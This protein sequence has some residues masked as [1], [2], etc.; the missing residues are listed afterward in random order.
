M[1]MR[2]ITLAVSA[3][4]IAAVATIGGTTVTAGAAD[5]NT[6]T[7]GTLATYKFTG[8]SNLA[9]NP[10]DQGG[11]AAQAFVMYWNGSGWRQAV[12][13]QWSPLG[14]HLYVADNYSDNRFAWG[15]IRDVETGRTYYKLDPS[16]SDGNADLNLSLPEGHRVRIRACMGTYYDYNYYGCTA[17]YSGRA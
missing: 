5:A 9:P 17:E 2:R 11:L 15:V 12:T 3:A 4:A 8:Y 6:D 13:V 16:T 14:E 1:R 10:P 7:I